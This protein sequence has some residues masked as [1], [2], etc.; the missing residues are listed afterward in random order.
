M[1]MMQHI[2][3]SMP[4]IIL[5]SIGLAFSAL[6]Q[7]QA[8]GA[9]AGAA[10][11]QLSPLAFKGIYEFGFTGI[12]FGKLGIEL[13][14]TAARYQV[15]CDIVTTGLVKLFVKHSSHTHAQGSGHDF[16]YSDITYQTDY[17]TKKKKKSARLVYK[18]GKVVEE[19]VT[20]PENRATRPAVEDKLKENTTDPLSL[21]LRIRQALFDAQRAH[22]GPF[23]IRYYDGRRLTEIDFVVQGPRIIQFNGQKTAVVEV[24]ASR[25]LIAGFTASELSS[26]NTKEP[27]LHIYFSQDKRLIPL[28]M[29][30]T[31]WMG[32]VQATLVKECA[33]GESC[34][35]G[36]AD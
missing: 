20:P 10:E 18:N 34:L 36:I 12:R 21:V 29:E 35:F 16:T 13:D 30:A 33:A 7:A 22:A 17:Q 3:N 2:Y 1:V 5:F 27:P 4:K 19:A 31:L 24:L 26:F 23:S 25:K 32:M 15:T 11:S 14:Q 9:Q 8:A 28:K 6:T